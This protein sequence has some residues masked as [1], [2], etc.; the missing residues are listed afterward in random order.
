KP[1]FFLSL[2]FLTISLNSFGQFQPTP[3]K[4]SNNQITI[5]GKNFYLHEVL[6]GQT[7]YGISK[8][9]QVSEEEIKKINPDLNKKSVSPGMVIRIPDP[10]LASNPVN[11]KDEVKF[12]AHTVLPKETL[13][14]ISRQYGIK[15]DQIR[16]LNPEV[17][18]GL[19]IGMNLKIPEDKITI[20]QKTQVAEEKLVK[21]GI[22]DSGQTSAKERAAQP[23]RVKPFPHE[24]DN[25]QLAL[26]LPL[27]I[28]QNDTLFYS[29]TLKPEH[30]RFY[31]FL[32]GIYLALD[33]M[34]LEGINMTVGVF[35]T[36]RN[37][38]TIKGIIE[39]DKLK[40]ADLIIGPVF[41]NEI[42]IVSAY[43]KSKNIPMVSPLSTYDVINNN[44]YAFQVRNK[45]PRQT[46]LATNYLGSK[47]NEN[48]IVISLLSEKENP[49]FTRFLG[50]LG[51]QIKEHDP[52]KKATFKTIYYSDTLRIFMNA[53]SKSIRLDSYLSSSESNFFILPSENEVFTTEVINELNQLSTVNKIHVFG[54]NQWVFAGL[55]LGNLYNVN[56]ELYSDF[57]D[58]NPFVDYNDPFVLN[59]CRKYKEN[60]NIEPSKYSFHGFDIAWFFTRAL[61]QFG[62]NLPSSVPCWTEYLSQPTMLTPMRFQSNSNGNGFENHAITVVRYQKDELFRKKVN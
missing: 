4:R 23:C 33:S 62:R 37:P 14:S 28:S 22:E 53:E 55:D 48:I 49:D 24:N 43:A 34:R 32:E 29:D 54:L 51:K 20:E 11:G 36:E 46:E 56:L 60:W 41:P 3:V 38:E 47:Y 19:K 27:N 6:K 39:S 13:F 17:R 25:F 1:L 44:P 10:G 45:L 30:F 18:S 16:E 40:E 57:E 5:S 50:N 52:A 61:F 8:E 9:Y 7:L 31:E 21:T 26:L 59:F 2:I 35:D 15:V 58:D 12:I 42:E